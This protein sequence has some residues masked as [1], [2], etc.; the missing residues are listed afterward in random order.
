MI[1]PASRYWRNAACAILIICDIASS[2][3]YK[4]KKK[5]RA[6]VRMYTMFLHAVRHAVTCYQI[7]ALWDIVNFI[8]LV[9]KHTALSSASV[10][11]TMRFFNTRACQ[12]YQCNKYRR[13]SYEKTKHELTTT[14]GHATNVTDRF[15]CKCGPSKHIETPELSGLQVYP[16][17]PAKYTRFWGSGWCKNGFIH[18]IV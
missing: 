16:L 2:M 6:C 14:L 5:K 8:L 12:N 9:Y 17:I 1:L 7:I 15:G 11:C 10:V 18:S 13:A 4:K 3:R